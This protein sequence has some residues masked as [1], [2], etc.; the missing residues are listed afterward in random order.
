MEANLLHLEKKIRGWMVFALL[1]AAALDI[2][3]HTR[4]MKP[5]VTVGGEFP[6]EVFSGVVTF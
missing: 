1:I 3:I 6:G 5:L 4:L 2:C